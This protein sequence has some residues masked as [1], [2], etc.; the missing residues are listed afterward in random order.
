MQIAGRTLHTNTLLW[1]IF[2]LSTLFM[3]WVALFYQ[4]VLSYYP[5]LVC[6]H[7]RLWVAGMLLAA[8][9]GLFTRA[10][11]RLQLLSWALLLAATAGFAERSWHTYAVERGWYV[12]SCEF[13]LG[14]PAWF[15][16][17]RWMPWAF[18]PGG[19]CGYT[20]EMLFGITMAQ[21]L[22]VVAAVSVALA[23]TGLVRC[24]RG[25]D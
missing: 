23:L 4:H 10:S 12:G 17:D 24:V 6:V 21:A 2:I 20:P 5:C 11:R 18:Q 1:M 7:V 13:E 15:A 16:V 14:M 22:L 19:A 25:A 3:E 9:L 8:L